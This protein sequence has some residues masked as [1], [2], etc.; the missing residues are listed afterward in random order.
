M[1]K[2]DATTAERLTEA[3]VAAFPG[4]VRSRLRDLGVVAGSRI[5]SAVEDAGAALEIDL[6]RELGLSAVEQARSPL[7]LVRAATHPV[8]QALES[9]GLRLQPR[10]EWLRAQYPEDVFDL[11]PA[12]SQDLGEDVWRLHIQWGI[13]KAK[14]V[15]G[16]VPEGAVGRSVQPQLA[17]FGVPVEHRGPL[18]D[19]ATSLGYGAS[20]WRN[21]AALEGASAAPPE[22]VLVD[23]SHGRAHDAIRLLAGNGIRVVAVTSQLDD[24]IQPGILALGAEEVI[25]MSSAAA[26]LD[27]LLPHIA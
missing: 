21:P 7:E 17:L 2:S 4:Y 16:V 3:L 8:T 18:L 11:Y 14:A 24:L 9:G 23:L 13:D 6:T 19:A 22:L 1:T 12:S 26:R 15:A 10:D 20:V 5:E 25:E 27:R